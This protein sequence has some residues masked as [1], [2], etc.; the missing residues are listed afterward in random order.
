MYEYIVV[1]FAKTKWHMRQ[2]ISNPIYNFDVSIL[3]NPILVF[4]S[5]L[6]F[7]IPYSCPKF[8][9]RPQMLAKRSKTF[10]K[11]TRFFSSYNTLNHVSTTYYEKKKLRFSKLHSNNYCKSFVSTTF[12]FY[13]SVNCLHLRIQTFYT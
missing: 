10:I 1:S 2:Q 6:H 12:K 9:S 13:V 5:S 11:L 4:E 8:I 7:S 3:C